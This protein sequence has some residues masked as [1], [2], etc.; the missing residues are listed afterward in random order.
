MWEFLIY[1]LAE[2][3]FSRKTSDIWQFGSKFLIWK[4]TH[5]AFQTENY[6]KKQF[7]QLRYKIIRAFM[8]GF[9]LN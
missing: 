9:I 3:G 8:K 6:K 1:R 5:L 2:S 7:K 4:N